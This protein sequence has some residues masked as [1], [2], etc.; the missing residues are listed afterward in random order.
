MRSYDQFIDALRDLEERMGQERD[1]G[2]RVYLRRQALGILDDDAAKQTQEGRLLLLQTE[3]VISQVDVLYAEAFRLIQDSLAN[4]FIPKDV[5]MD[6][7]FAL[8]IGR[9]AQ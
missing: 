2:E 5:L 3:R 9:L 7:W 8:Q 4:P 6:L 1:L